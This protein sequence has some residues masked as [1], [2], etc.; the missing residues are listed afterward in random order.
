MWYA[1]ET[2]FVDGQLLASE[3]VFQEG[4][5][6]PLGHC[7]ASL[8]EEPMNMCEKKFFDRLEIHTDWFESEELA[9]QFSEGKITYV[10]HYDAYYSPGIRST[11]TRFT[12]R[13][14]VA[15]DEEKGYFP[16]RGVRQLHKLDYRPW[17]AR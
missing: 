7:Y 2:A 17:W 15:V 14:I 3:C 11:R 13:E 10:H 6:S 9:K 8:S 5:T 16:Y 4:D 1:V 12:K